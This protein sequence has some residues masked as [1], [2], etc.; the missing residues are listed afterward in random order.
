MSVTIDTIIDDEPPDFGKKGLATQV[1]ELH[2]KYNLMVNG[3]FV[4]GDTEAEE[5]TS[6]HFYRFLVNYEIARKKRRVD[7]MGQK[8]NPY[9]VVE[10]YRRICDGILSEHPINIF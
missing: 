4:T 10:Y 1:T 6:Y 7:I 9:Q 8:M 2:L 5:K 3:Y